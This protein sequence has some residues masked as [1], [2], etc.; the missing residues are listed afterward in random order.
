M[1]Q[2]TISALVS[3]R[4]R[5]RFLRS[6][7]SQAGSL[8]DSMYRSLLSSVPK[9]VWELVKQS[10]PA[11]T[12]ES[13][14]SALRRVTVQNGGDPLGTSSLMSGILRLFSSKKKWWAFEKCIGPHFRLT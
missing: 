12:I 2:G 3:S 10:A 8:A 7:R 13:A 5:Q 11:T 9:L 14:A 4:C 6:H 1:S